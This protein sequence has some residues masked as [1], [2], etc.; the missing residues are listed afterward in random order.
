M[1]QIAEWRFLVRDEGEA[2]LAEDATWQ[3]D[4]EPAA[5]VTDSW[6]QGSVPIV[7]RSLTP[8]PEQRKV[9][10][11][12]ARE[13]S[14]PVSPAPGR[15]LL[16][17]HRSRAGPVGASFPGRAGGNP[18]DTSALPVPPAVTE[19]LLRGCPGSGQGQG[20]GSSPQA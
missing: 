2:G 20:P 10:G 18:W 19:P 14:F 4:E 16:G 12:L 9:W 3:E 17:V 8:L 1:L 7:R 11:V 15:A 5:C 13:S 6:A